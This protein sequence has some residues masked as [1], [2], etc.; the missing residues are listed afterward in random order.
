MSGAQEIRFWRTPDFGPGRGCAVFLD[1]AGSVFTLYVFQN[2][3]VRRAQ[4]HDEQE[5][6]AAFNEEVRRLAVLP[7]N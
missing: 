3:P 4:Y 7:S 6:V 5:A 2:G 1:R